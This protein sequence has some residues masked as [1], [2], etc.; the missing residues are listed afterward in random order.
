M[1]KRVVF[2]MVILFLFL[3][4][5]A[6]CNGDSADNGEE[7]VETMA[8]EDR[9]YINDDLLVSVEWVQENLEDEDL[10]V[11]DARGEDAYKGG[12]IPGAVVTAW[13]SFADVEAS[14]GEGFGVLLAPEDLSPLFQNL[15]VEDSKTIVVYADPNGWGED[16]RL[17]WMFRMAGLENTH[18]LDGGWPAWTEGDFEV[19]REGTEPTPSNIE[20]TNF[21]D[22]M[23]VS[24]DWLAENRED[25][26][27]LDTRTENEYNGA[28]DF[29]EARGGHIAGATH[30]FW[31]DLF[32]LDY[33][34]KTQSEIESIMEDLGVEKSDTIVAYCTAG[35]R[36]A[37]TALVLRMAG[38]ENAK[39]YDASFYEWSAIDDL[40]VE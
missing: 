38:Y 23:T 33:T 3:P 4:L 1:K 39:N 22:D 15:G 25:V 40:P 28:T 32:N 24:T 26:V 16:G 11:I 8:I 19:S 17:V 10:L 5:L 30:L 12:H 35:I 9:G 14:H 13:Q 18:I 36:S 31:A 2:I 37:H 20:I 21:N 7:P 27:V 34:V 29:G 6:G